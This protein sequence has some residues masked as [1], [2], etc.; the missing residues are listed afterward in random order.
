[1]PTYDYE[2]TQCGHVHEKFHAISD[3]PEKVCPECGGLLKRLIGTGAGIIFKG[4]GFYATDYRSKEYKEKAK[5]EAG[6]SP[7]PA[8]EKKTEAGGS[9]EKK[10]AATPP[11]APPKKAP[12]GE[13]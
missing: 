3:E 13:S 9:S 1:M 8:A 2:C 6:S 7:A 10:P 5:S 4:G 11:P 12:S